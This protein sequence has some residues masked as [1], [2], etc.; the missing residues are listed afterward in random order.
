MKVFL[1]FV[2]GLMLFTV[3]AFQAT[4]HGHGQGKGKGRGNG[5]YKSHYK[6]PKHYCNARCHAGAHHY[7]REKVVIVQPVQPRPLIN[8]SL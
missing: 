5:H 2:F 6:K 1:S 4:A 3:L 8:I 7:Y